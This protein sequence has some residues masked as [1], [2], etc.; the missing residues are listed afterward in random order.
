MDIATEQQKHPGLDASNSQTTALNPKVYS[1]CNKP[2]CFLI[3]GVSNPPPIQIIK[4]AFQF[5]SSRLMGLI[6]LISISNIFTS[7]LYP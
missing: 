7:K 3:G 5:I 2:C 1:H 4:C 6:A